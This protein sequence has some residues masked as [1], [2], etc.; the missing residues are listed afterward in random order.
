[1]FT[2]FYIAT[3]IVLAL[4]SAYWLKRFPIDRAA[5]EARVALLERDCPRA[6]RR[7]TFHPL[8]RPFRP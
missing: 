4:F 1:M 5:H 7:R 2:I 3:A 8:D 6:S